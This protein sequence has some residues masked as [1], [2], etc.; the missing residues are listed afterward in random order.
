M[1]ANFLKLL[2]SQLISAFW[3]CWKVK[4]SAYR[5]YVPLRV[6]VMISGTGGFVICQFEVLTHLPCVPEAAVPPA[7]LLG[8]MVSCRH[9]N[10]Q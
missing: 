4:A 7:L 5:A 1:G 6:E 9:F 8:E 10:V 3:Q 2:D